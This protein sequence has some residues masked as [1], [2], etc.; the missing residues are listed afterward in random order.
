MLYSPI[1]TVVLLS[2]P[3]GLP[4][5]G[6]SS[7][8]SAA[9]RIV[10]STTNP[11]PRQAEW[12]WYVRQTVEFCWSRNVLALQIESGRSSGGEGFLL[13]QWPRTGGSQAVPGR[14][15]ADQRG[16]V[17]PAAVKAGGASVP[18]A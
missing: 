2:S 7:R 17:S 13:C 1:F 11:L 9:E 5:S 8:R 16:R 12:V 14:G 15:A 18:P 4:I 10:P 3:S 6:E